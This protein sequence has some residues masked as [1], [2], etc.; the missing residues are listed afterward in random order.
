MKWFA[1][2]LVS[3]ASWAVG[4]KGETE[5]QEIRRLRTQAAH[6]EATTS[7][8]YERLL[9]AKDSKT[10][11]N[12]L[13]LRRQLSRFLESTEIIRTPMPWNKEDQL[14][15]IRARSKVQGTLESPLLEQL[16]LEFVAGRF[17]QAIQAAARKQ[18]TLV[19]KYCRDARQGYLLLSFLVRPGET[20]FGF[21][22]VNSK[23]LLFGLFDRTLVS[24]GPCPQITDYVTQQEFVGHPVYPGAPEGSNGRIFT[25][26]GKYR[27]VAQ[28]GLTNW[29]Y[30]WEGASY[31]VIF[32]P[33][34][35]DVA[36]TPLGF[37]EIILQWGERA[38]CFKAKSFRLES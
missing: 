7:E 21:E 25:F 5:L 15:F 19:Q 17:G 29:N 38:G 4:P 28:Y 30:A 6:F 11:S 35:R 8:K 27:V 22:P 37:K 31:P 36:G 24:E 1:I 26:E 32:D 2:I 3:T 18:E 9:A 12:L 23:L 20:R 14:E 10:V 13:E 33:F 16:T 34:G